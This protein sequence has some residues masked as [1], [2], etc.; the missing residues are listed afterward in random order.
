MRLSPLRWLLP[1]LLALSCATTLAP[2]APP[3]SRTLD[4]VIEVPGRP[5]LH[6]VCS[7]EGEPLVILD[8]GLGN[9]S[10]IWSR[11]Q[12]E[13][14]RSTR[15][16]AYD[17]AGLGT[18]GLAPRP[19]SSELMA[20]EL[21]DLL[22]AAHVPAPYVLVGHSL[23]GANI[24]YFAARHPQD[25]VGMVLVDAA[26]EQQPSRY[27]SLLPDSMI[28]EFKIGLNAVGIGVP[29]DAVKAKKLAEVTCQELQYEPAC[30]AVRTSDFAPL[31]PQVPHCGSVGRGGGGMFVVAPV[32]DPRVNAARTRSPAPRQ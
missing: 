11:V 5:S 28:A 2:K 9:D 22:R 30:K 12:P 23:G 1:S 21:H 16:C 25:V 4:A 6:L 10:S 15:V 7:G 19:H 31:A 32:A 14:A 17:R 24:R 29:K 26:T 27:W 3:P 20:E 18:S 8:A 13:L